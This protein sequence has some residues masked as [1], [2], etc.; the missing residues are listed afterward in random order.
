MIDTTNNTTAKIEGQICNGE[1]FYDHYLRYRDQTWELV[2]R[3]FQTRK[4]WEKTIT[5]YMAVNP[6]PWRRKGTLRILETPWENWENASLNWEM[7]F[8]LDNQ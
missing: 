2:T 8:L 5:W 7:W 1:S 6:L 3:I 4:L